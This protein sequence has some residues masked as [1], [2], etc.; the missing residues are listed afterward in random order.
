MEMASK[1]FGCEN[2]LELIEWFELSNCYA[3]I[4]EQPSPCTDV[5]EFCKH[6][7]GRLSEPLAG[8]IM[9]QVIQAARHCFDRGVLHGDIKAENLL[10]NTDT[11]DVKLKDFGCGALLKDSPYTRYAGKCIIGIGENQRQCR[12]ELFYGILDGAL[13]LFH[14]GTWAFCPPE[15]ICEGEYLGYP[16]TV[17]SLGV[18]LFNL[19]CRDLP[20][21]NEDGNV[22]QNLRLAPDLSEGKEMQKHYI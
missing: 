4:L 14:S 22:H 19:V 21:H 1:P 16:A 17:W 5:L 13:I 7:K 2:V 18:L 9:C 3:L 6:Y 11:L 20:L 10:I 12:G 8:H 15:W